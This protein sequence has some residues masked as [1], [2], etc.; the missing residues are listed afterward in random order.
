MPEHAEV[1]IMS[2]FVNK[3]SVDRTFTRIYRVERG[4]VPHLIRDGMFS[5]RSRSVGKQIELV[6]G[7]DT[8]Y[9]FMGMTGNWSFVPTAGWS[10]TR[11]VRLRFD[12]DDGMSL[13]LHGGYMGPKFSLNKPFTGQRRGPDPVSDPE[14]FRSNVMS[15]IGSRAFYKPL[16]EI[17]LDQRYFNGVGAY[18]C[19]EI[20]GRICFSPFDSPNSIGDEGV[21]R[22]VDMTIHCIDKSYEYGG[23][24]LI[25]WKSPLGSSRIDEWIRFY[26]NT[27]SC[28]RY[29]FGSRNIWIERRWLPQAG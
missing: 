16:G 13:I 3:S 15:A 27:Q 26:G 25:D 24:E 21:S 23:G 29:K 7:N 1:R 2:E 11:F 19:A 8:F 22:L 20:L 18:L 17:L 9:I 12:S 6:A 10:E 4:N 14:L 28:V 5:V